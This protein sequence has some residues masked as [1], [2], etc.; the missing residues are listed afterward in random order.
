M[1]EFLLVAVVGL[2][3]WADFI[4]RRAAFR[5]DAAALS[6]WTTIVQFL[7]VMPLF[8]MAGRL[9][10]TQIGV[11]ALVGAFTAL[12]RIPWYR[13]LSTPGQKLSRLAPF[14]RLSSVIVVILAFTLLGEAF[15][16]DKLVGA[17]L[18]VGGALVI[19]LDRSFTGFR[20]F[21]VGNK[22]VLLVLIFA[23]S[24][25]V[26]SVFYKYMLNAGVPIITTYFF[27]K[28]FQC[29]ASIAH[30]YHRGGLGR[31][32]SAILD[33]QLFVRAR[34]LQTLAAF[35]YLFVLR[36]VDL[37]TVEPI[38]AAIGPLLYLTIDKVSDWRGR[39]APPQTVGVTPPQSRS[40]REYVA[41][42]GSAV[43]ALGLYFVVKG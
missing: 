29:A 30:G 14:T 26:I 28:L 24:L 22:A 31:S 40:K 16:F 37:S 42:L 23:S 3:V 17:L 38:A 27:L 9:T 32:F 36:H 20:D 35:L 39:A 6:L 21:F 41:L 2:N 7:L 1:F 43:T 10:P 15:S 33:L 25:A 12:A 13:A 4:D 34:A 8:G 18:M 11:C 5:S 19:S